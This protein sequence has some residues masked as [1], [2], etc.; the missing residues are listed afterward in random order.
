MTFHKTGDVEPIGK[1]LTPEEMKKRNEEKPE[2]K[3]VPEKK[4]SSK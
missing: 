4:D 3:K 1:P 2:P